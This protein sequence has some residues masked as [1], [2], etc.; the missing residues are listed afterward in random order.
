MV[1]T[2]LVVVMPTIR[3][4]G[5]AV[6]K[7]GPI[8]HLFK[9]EGHGVGIS[10]AFSTLDGV[11]CIDNRAGAARKDTHERTVWEE[12]VTMDLVAQSGEF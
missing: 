4:V 6:V 9:G 8:F 1:D 11:R 7:A 12:A 5:V 3:G 10:K 2:T